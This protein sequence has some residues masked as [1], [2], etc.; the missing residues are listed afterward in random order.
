MFPPNKRLRWNILL[1]WQGHTWQGASYVRLYFIPYTSPYRV[2]LSTPKPSPHTNNSRV[3]EATKF[4]LHP[5]ASLK[6]L[7]AGLYIDR[8][9]SRELLNR[10]EC[11][12]DTTPMTLSRDGL[13]LQAL[14]GGGWQ[15]TKSQCRDGAKPSWKVRSNAL[16]ELHGHTLS[17][18]RWTSKLKLVSTTR[19]PPSKT[20]ADIPGV[21]C[22]RRP[23]YRHVFKIFGRY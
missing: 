23:E 20:E 13:C 15:V 10:A 19:N 16:A 22:I 5:I 9:E 1:T 4:E 17:G 21:S 3:W 12:D 8:A 11:D 14:P 6:M 2:C 7:D 18:E